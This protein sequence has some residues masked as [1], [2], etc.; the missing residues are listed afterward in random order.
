[1]MLGV[2]ASLNVI[3]HELMQLP[4]RLVIFLAGPQED[5]FENASE[6]DVGA[7]EQCSADESGAHNPVPL[8][9]FGRWAAAIFAHSYRPTSCSI[10]C[11]L[12]LCIKA[13]EAS[14]F[15]KI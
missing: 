11:H 12:Q 4:S 10:C 14:F 15:F 5:E 13:E 7:K 8:M 6:D 1:M 2:N 9:E 3:L